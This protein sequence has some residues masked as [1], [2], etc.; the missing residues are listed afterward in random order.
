MSLSVTIRL[1]NLS[2]YGFLG[3]PGFRSKLWLVNQ[4]SSDFGG[5]YEWDSVQDAYN[6]AASYAMKFSRWRSLP[7]HFRAEL[8]PSSDPQVYY[9]LLETT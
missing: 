3:L 6:Y 8:F 5:I 1:S 9:Q 2:K 7:A 4:Q